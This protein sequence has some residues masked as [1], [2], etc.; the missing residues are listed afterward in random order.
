[1]LEQLLVMGPDRR[2][3]IGGCDGVDLASPAIGTLRLTLRQAVATLRDTNFECRVDA[4]TV[5]IDQ[6]VVPASAIAAT[7][8]LATLVA[9]LR[10]VGAASV[11]IRYGATAGELL[12]L[13]RYLVQP[14]TLA[15]VP[16][17]LAA[18]VG[19]PLES[20]LAR[21]LQPGAS[22]TVAVDSGL[23]RTWSV[24]LLPDRPVHQSDLSM[25]ELL[26]TVRAAGP[27]DAATAV[28][29]SFITAAVERQDAATLATLAV[30]AMRTAARLGT[31]AGRLGMEAV[32]RALLQPAVIRLVAQRVPV[33]HAVDTLCAYFARAGK[34]GASTLLQAA[35]ESVDPHVRWAYVDALATTHVVPDE[36]AAVLQHPQ[37]AAVCAAVGLVADLGGAGAEVPLIAILKHEDPT[38]RLAVAGGLV[39]LQVGASLAAVQALITDPLPA[40]RRLAALAAATAASSGSG[41]A[42]PSAVPL[43]AALDVET[44][45]EVRLEL[46]LALGRIASSDAIQRLMRL[47]LAAAS[48]TDGRD[49]VLRITALDGLVR[50]RGGQALSVIKTLETDPDVAVAAAAKAHRSALPE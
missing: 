35:M 24:T 37:P 22:E 20:S 36:L 17:L 5:A 33:T 47:A 16:R 15:E 43:S 28:V 27:N 26:R 40:F 32:I 4:E 7:R 50:A 10:A 6:R 30:E 9:R 25:M 11:Q 38:V 12:L 18:D 19:T 34:I 8:P 41:M 14:A 44:D 46:V 1:M 42:R 23:L 29:R 49:P 3:V 45:A 39:R 48:S 21:A 13:A 2:G 31:G